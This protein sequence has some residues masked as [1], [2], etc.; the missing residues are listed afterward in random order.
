MPPLKISVTML[1]KNSARELA[2]VLDSVRDFDEVVILDSGSTDATLDIARRF[3]NTRIHTARFNGFGPMHNQA[4]ALARNDWIFSLDSDEVVSAELAQELASLALDENAVY[5]IPMHNYYNGKWIRWCG[6]YP[7]RH[8]R[9]FHRKKTGFTEAEVHEA[10]MTQGLREVALTN[11][12]RHYSYS[13]VADFIAKTQLY[14]DLFARQ[15]QGKKKS[16]LGKA[17]AHGAATFVKCFVVKRGFLGGREGFIISASNA[18]GTFYKYLK[19][20]EANEKG[21]C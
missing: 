1:T 2:R 7:D 3:S 12:V 6:W 15:Y 8:V 21:R 20:L 9:L 5:S 4:V 14:S 17:V 18:Y 10:V 16:S 13:C 19:L 11:P